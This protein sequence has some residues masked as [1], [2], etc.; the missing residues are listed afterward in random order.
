MRF[1]DIVNPTMQFGAVIYPTVRFGAVLKY[2]K[3][4][5]AV[6][7]GFQMSGTLRCGS[8]I[9]EI[10]R[11]GSV[12]F[13]YF[14]K[15]TVRCGAVFKRQKSYGAVRCTESIGKNRTVKNPAN[16]DTLMIR[17][18]T[19]RA[20]TPT[21]TEHVPM[22]CLWEVTSTRPSQR[23]RFR[24]VCPLTY[25]RYSYL[26][27]IN[28]TSDSILSEKQVSRNICPPSHARGVINSTLVPLTLLSEKLV[29]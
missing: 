1:S 17:S 11:C 7:C 20:Q 16:F 27:N 25:Q 23:R 10:L 21:D 29:S 2:R 9:F 26:I 12:R 6:R 18:T 14:V 24:C 3:C 22:I 4:Y 13:S 5:G 8:V 15:P 19:G 28:S